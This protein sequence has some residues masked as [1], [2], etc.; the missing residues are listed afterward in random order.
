MKKNSKKRHLKAVLLVMLAAVAVSAVVLLNTA[1]VEKALDVS[2]VKESEIKTATVGSAGDIMLH[3]PFYRSPDYK[4]EDGSYDF[5]DCFKFIEQ[6]YSKASYMAVNLETTLAGGGSGYSG[7]P[8]F[9]SPDSIADSLSESGVDLMLLANNHIYDSGKEGFMRTSQILAEKGINYTGARHSDDEKKYIVKD[10]EGIKI[11]I[12]NFTYETPRSDDLKG[13]NG[14]PVDEESAGYL[15]SF[16]PDDREAFYNEMRECLNSMENDGAEF[17]IVYLHWGEEYNLKESGWQREIAQKLCDMGV[18]ALIGS[19]PHVVQPV[20]VFKSETGDDKE[21]LMFC[22]FSVGN[23]L[24]NQRREMMNLN[25]GHTEDGLVIYLD[26]KKDEERTYLSGVDYVP[27]WVY[28]NQA[29]PVYY[30]LPADNAADIETYTGI[31]GIR[32]SVED[33]Y[34]RTWSIIEEG[35]SKVR[36]A[37][38]FD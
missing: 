26:I 24:S 27:T 13:I 23:Q 1:P 33:S 22:A 7:Y 6:V 9:R 12:V 5:S 36:E 16:D 21:H 17:T 4:T 30:I 29:G 37:Y 35:A 34:E 15:N 38:G 2:A 3:S 28:K 25:T 20:D 14:N 10:V 8:M 18:D 19:H 11:G 32:Q 31:G